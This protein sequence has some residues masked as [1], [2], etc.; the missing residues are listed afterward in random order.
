MYCKRYRQTKRVEK[1]DTEVSLPQ[2]DDT[3]TPMSTEEQSNIVSSSSDS[4]GSSATESSKMI[5]RL[6]FSK[7]EKRKVT[8]SKALRRS[9]YQK[10]ALK[11]KISAQRKAAEKWKKKYKRLERRLFNSRNL[12]PITRD[13]SQFQATQNQELTP[14]S[15]TT[16]EIR[17][18]GLSP[19]SLPKRIVKRL[20]LSNC[21]VKEIEVAKTENK[22]RKEKSAINR[23]VSGNIS[24]KYRLGSVLRKELKVRH[25]VSKAVKKKIEITQRRGNLSKYKNMKMTINTFFER[26]DVSRCMPGKK[27][28]VKVNGE[29]KQTRILNDYLRN[30]RDK[31]L[32]ENT[33]LRIS[34]QLFAK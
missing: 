31:F 30:L 10:D 20:E 8:R 4:M 29:K 22:K 28:A 9:W 21:L 2:I 5:V 16:H 13:H 32:S 24:R 17:E 27:D 26:D 33:N 23:I 3:C 15:K 12:I 7:I 6:D 11:K 34:Y 25:T 19:S 18:N 14:K 1:N